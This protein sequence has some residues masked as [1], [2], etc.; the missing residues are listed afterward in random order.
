MPP[1][2]GR[3][4]WRNQFHDHPGRATKREDAFIVAAGGTKS[5]KV[6][7]KPCFDAD[8]AEIAMRDEV[9]LGLGRRNNVRSR[10]EIVTYR[11]S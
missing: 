1:K 8:L 3:S 9:D 5:E 10:D 7:C 2:A 11:M 6:Y 4:W